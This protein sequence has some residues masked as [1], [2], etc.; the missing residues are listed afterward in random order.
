M[1]QAKLPN[2]SRNQS[3]HQRCTYDKRLQGAQWKNPTLS[4]CWALFCIQPRWW[5][6]RPG[7]KIAHSAS[8]RTTKN[9][10]QGLLTSGIIAIVYDTS[11]RRQSET[12]WEPDQSAVWSSWILITQKNKTTRPSAW[13]RANQTTLLNRPMVTTMFGYRLT[14]VLFHCDHH[15]HPFL[16]RPSRSTIL[17]SLPLPLTHLPNPWHTVPP[18]FNASENGKGSPYSPFQNSPHSPH[19]LEWESIDRAQSQEVLSQNGMIKF[20]LKYILLGG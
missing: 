15:H 12:C 5:R 17:Y 4:K 8:L 16:V 14:L 2:Q 9:K 13:S 6:S 3:D 11:G 18:A 7:F 1:S 10:R 19:C 20:I